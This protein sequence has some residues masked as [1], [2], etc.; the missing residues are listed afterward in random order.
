[1]ENI[2]VINT[3]WQPP[4]SL[5][6]K[7][8][9]KIEGA[10]FRAWLAKPVG[11]KFLA[12]EA[13]RVNSIAKTLF[14]YNA[15]IL[16][17][18]EFA[19]CLADN[20]IKNKLLLNG[21]LSLSKIVDPNLVLSRHDRLGIGNELIDLVYLA[22]SL[23]FTQNPHE[24]LCEAY[25]VL[26]PDGHLIISMFNLLSLW[27]LWRGVAKL[28]QKSPWKSNFMSLVKLKDWL[29][30]MGFDIMRVNY[31][32]YNLPL[33]R[34]GSKDELA[35]LSIFERYGQRLDLPFGAAFVV[36]AAKRVIPLTA[37]PTTWRAA[38][39]IIESDVTEP[40]PQ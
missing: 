10:E 19:C 12:L 27:G 35:Q 22:H 1:M 24:I 21:D 14:G 34:L 26:R 5:S 25:R 2:V 9:M 28:S 31:F 18:P 37:I 39:D 3:S 4:G 15:A 40:T 11:Q 17:E 6:A 8:L 32:G 16:G 13:S 7:V 38:E 29:A 36:E 23:E 30:V 33:N 20:P